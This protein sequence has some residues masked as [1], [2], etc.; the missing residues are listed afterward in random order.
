MSFEGVLH[1]EAEAEARRGVLYYLDEADD[2]NIGS[3]DRW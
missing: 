3:M 2:P 1:E